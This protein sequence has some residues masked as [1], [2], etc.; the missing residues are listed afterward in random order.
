MLTPIRHLLSSIIDYAGIFPPASLT[1]P[2]AIDVYARARASRRSWMLGRFVIPVARLAE[3]EDCAARYVDQTSTGPWSL[4]LIS[5]GEVAAEKERIDDLR[6]RQ[7]RL[8]VEAV[9]I[10]W[11]APD[12]ITSAARDVPSG[13]EVFFEIP[14]DIDLDRPLRAI[15]EVHAAAKVRTGGPTTSAFPRSKDLA[16]FIEACGRSRVPFKATA[17]LHH[18]FCG[19]YPLNETT[20]HMHGFLNVALAAALL[21]SGKTTG[22]ETLDVLED[23]GPDAFRFGPDGVAWRDRILKDSDLEATRRNF[24]R[25]FGSCSFEEPVDGIE[26]LH[27]S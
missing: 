14:T 15:A 8:M 4:S 22:A 20:F 26:A 10:P 9:E 11:L 5:S 1:L 19:E 3:F 16:N 21:W 12:E 2:E 7:N 18:L 13:L 25:S 6:R 24:F 27:L 23:S 17:G